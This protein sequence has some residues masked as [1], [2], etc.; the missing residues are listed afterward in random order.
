MICKKRFF[1]KIICLKNTIYYRTINLLY[2]TINPMNELALISVKINKFHTPNLKSS[3]FNVEAAH[4]VYAFIS[5]LSN[6]TM[7]LGLLLTFSKIIYY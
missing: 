4:K 1:A 3:C 5:S 7:Q 2:A 6:N